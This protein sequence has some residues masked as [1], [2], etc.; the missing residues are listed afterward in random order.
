MLPESNSTENRKPPVAE[1]VALNK[2]RSWPWPRSTKDRRQRGRGEFALL[3]PKES[4]EKEKSR[5]A[6]GTTGCREC[7][8]GQ[9]GEIYQLTPAPHNYG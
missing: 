7:G 8:T 1:T 2:H 3:I 4:Y 9:G 6:A 5:N